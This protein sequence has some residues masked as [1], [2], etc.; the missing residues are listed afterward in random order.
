MSFRDLL[1]LVLFFLILLFASLSETGAAERTLVGPFPYLSRADSPFDL[2]GL[3]STF[4]LEDF[5]SGAIASLGLRLYGNATAVVRGPGDFTDSVDGD[6]GEIDG[7]GTA[8]HSL[9][10]AGGVVFLPTGIPVFIRDI[11]FQFDSTQ[12]G[13]L[14]TVFGFVWTD[15]HQ[16]SFVG[17][18][19]WNADGERT[20]DE[21]RGR[22]GD[23]S[24]L[25][26]TSEDRFFGITRADGISRVLVRTL[27]EGADSLFEIDHVQYGLIIP[28]ASAEVMLLSGIFSACVLS[29]TQKRSCK[30][31]T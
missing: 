1:F 19:T 7:L 20:A 3:G 6:D 4:F 18:L 15:G 29:L 22:V 2:S 31:G 13:F 24:R 16:D 11:G 9:L 8:G 30:K 10:D 26:E 12:L 23:T 28:E 27:V 5:E 25:G 21:F 14:P 17:I